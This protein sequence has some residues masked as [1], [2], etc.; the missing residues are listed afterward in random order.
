MNEYGKPVTVWE[1]D[2]FEMPGIHSIIPIQFIQCRIV[3]PID[4]IFEHD[5]SVLFVVSYVINYGS[6]YRVI[7]I[8]P[9]VIL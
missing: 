7:I 2:L 9:S 3:T 6:S 8:L 5:P 4:K 1:C